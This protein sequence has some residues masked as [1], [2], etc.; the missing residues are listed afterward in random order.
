MYDLPP[1]TVRF[2]LLLLILLLP[3]AVGARAQP[4][5]YRIGAPYP[6]VTDPNLMT[7]NGIP[8]TGSYYYRDYPYP[9]L[10]EALQEYGLFGH[11]FQARAAAP[12]AMPTP[13]SAALIRVHL[14]ADA[15]LRLGGQVTSQRGAWRRFVTPPLPSGPALGYEVEA[16]WNE[17]GREIRQSRT[18]RVE[19]GSEVVVDFLTGGG[20]SS[21]L[22]PPRPLPPP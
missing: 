19:P 17:R 9:S 5:L 12:A 7:D 22:P 18:V 16:R 10:R 21:I 20:D 8:G 11:R 14:P 1:W 15:E 4:P 6:P 2:Y 3:C 13:S